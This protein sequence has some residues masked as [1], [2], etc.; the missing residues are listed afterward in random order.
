MNGGV[1]EVKFT[2]SMY[3]CRVFWDD[4][5][6]GATKG[7]NLTY[8]EC[9]ALTR[10]EFATALVLFCLIPGEGRKGDSTNT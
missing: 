9:W 8:F 6:H 5:F 2:I 3:G 7:S 4:A 1:G 10:R